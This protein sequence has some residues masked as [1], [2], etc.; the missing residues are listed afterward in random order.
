MRI[1]RWYLSMGL[2]LATSTAIAGDDGIKVLIEGMPGTEFTASWHLVPA[3]G[4]AERNGRWEGAVPQA[5]ALPN[6]QLDLTLIQSSETGHLE[7]TVTAGGNR[8]RSL[9][10]GQGGRL[11][12]SVR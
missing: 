4:K 2:A 5:Y 9:T 7:V 12:L 1:G 11:Q 8:S 10:Q 3:D 6:G